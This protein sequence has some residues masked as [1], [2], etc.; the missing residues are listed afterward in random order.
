MMTFREVSEL[1]FELIYEQFM[2]HD[3]PKNELKE[4][5]L[6]KETYKKEKYTCFVMEEKKEIRAYAC[7]TWSKESVQILDYLAVVGSVRGKGYGGQLLTWVKENEKIKEI[8]IESEDPDFA[9]DDIE[10]EIRYKRLSFYEKNGMRKRDLCIKLAGV[11]YNIFTFDTSLLSNEELLEEMLTIY[12]E[13]SSDL[14]AES[15]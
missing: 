10:K 3:F 15:Y 5:A 8:I 11:E 7:F 6:I 9:A 14:Q 12:R 1:E 13:I 2:V 4:L